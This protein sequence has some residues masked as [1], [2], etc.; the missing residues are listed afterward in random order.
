M[1]RANI[2][3]V[4]VVAIAW[5]LDLAEEVDIESCLLIFHEMG[6]RYRSTNVVNVLN[7]HMLEEIY[8]DLNEP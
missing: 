1:A 6:H 4:I 7:H 5:Y 8:L 2:Y 3:S